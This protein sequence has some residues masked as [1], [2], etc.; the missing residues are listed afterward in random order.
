MTETSTGTRSATRTEPREGLVAAMSAALSQRPKNGPAWLEARRA[1]AASR[2]E[3]TGFPAATDEAFRFT[4]LAAVLRVPYAPRGPS[5]SHATAAFGNLNLPSIR[6]ENGRVGEIPA[7]TGVEVRRIADVLRQEPGLLDPYL[8][9][10]AAS[11]Q[12]FV[13]QNTALFEDGVMVVA[14][15]RAKGASHLAYTGN[16]AEPTLVTPRVVVVAEPESELTLI[17]SHA[18]EGDYLESAVTELFIGGGAAVEHVRADLGA[19]KV[20]SL[21]TI[22]ARQGR[23]SRYRSRIFG[24]GGSLG[25]V[26][27][28]VLLEEPGAE[29]SLD[30]LYLAGSGALLD[31]HTVIDHL[32]PRCSSRERYKGILDGNGVAVFDGTIIV[33]RGAS[34]TEA[35]QENRNLLLSNE[36]VVHAKPHLEIDTDDVRCSHG[37]TVGRLD[38]AQLFYLRSRGIDAEVARSLLTYAFAREMVATVTLPELREALEE[39]IA[40]R[41]PSGALARGLA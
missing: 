29:C 20:A 2:L 34:G 7:S 32:S 30:G 6:I 21:S 38:P 4:P 17:E 10:L 18:A 22:V 25:R 24:F 40:E 41:L 14:R 5:R 28:R 31:H 33:R 37:A 8:G 9:R 12:G 23:D 15:P 3:L 11:E 19:P 16:A 27:A 26:E 36:A 39:L 35:H 1:E 13:A